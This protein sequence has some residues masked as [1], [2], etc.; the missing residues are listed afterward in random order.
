MMDH[1]LSG[2]SEFYD[3]AGHNAKY[4]EE[5]PAIDPHG[6]IP[7]HSQH[8]QSLGQQPKAGEK[9]E[10]DQQEPDKTGFDPDQYQCSQ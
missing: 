1:L 4:N 6:D 2:F 9:H 8:V 3:S 10:A 7:D 5:H